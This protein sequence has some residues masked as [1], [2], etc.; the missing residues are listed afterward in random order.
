MEAVSV[1]EMIGEEDGMTEGVAVVS[2]VVEGAAEM[3]E[4]TLT[5]SQPYNLASFSIFFTIVP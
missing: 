1:A 2:T 4:G 5:F 3:I